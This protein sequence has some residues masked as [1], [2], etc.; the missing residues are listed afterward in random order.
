MEIMNATEA[1]DFY[2]KVLELESEEKKKE[3]NRIRQEREAFIKKQQ[4]EMDNKIKEAYK[5][6]I[7]GKL[8]TWYIFLNPSL[9]L[10]KKDYWS[11]YIQ[12]YVNKYNTEKHKYVVHNCNQGFTIIPIKKIKIQPID[13]DD[14]NTDGS[15]CNCVIV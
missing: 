4:N 10:S 1:Y 2:S 12:N 5:L 15:V 7:N 13:F 6:Y 8:R 11:T 3:L 14:I 9:S